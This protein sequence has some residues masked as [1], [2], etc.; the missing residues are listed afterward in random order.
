MIM[1]FRDFAVSRHG[2]IEDSFMRK[3]IALPALT[4]IA[5][6]LLQACAT[7]PPPP[8]DGRAYARPRSP[9]FEKF[10]SEME[11]TGAAKPAPSTSAE[12]TT[13]STP[14][15]NYKVYGGTGQTV[16]PATETAPTPGP[17][18]ATLAFEATD[19]R[20]VVKTV[21]F[22]ILG[23]NYYIDPQVGGNVTFRT[24][25]PVPRNT[26]IPILDML[27]RGTNA[28]LIREAGIYKV[29]PATQAVRGTTTPQLISG[30]ANVPPGHSV[31]VMPL[32]YIG[33]KEMLRIL[34]PFAK[35]AASIRG[36]ELRNLVILTGTEREIRHLLETVEMFDIDWMSGMSVGFFQLQSVDVKNLIKEFETVFGNKELGPLAGA[37]RVVPIERLNA[38]LVIAPQRAMIDKAREWIERLDSGG[39]AD[40]LKLFVYHLQNARADK[41]APILQQALTGR[42]QI[43]ST[44]PQVAPGQTPVQLG[45]GPSIG[46]SAAQ[47]AQTA[48]QQAQ[49]QAAQA[50]ARSAAATSNVAAATGGGAELAVSRNV[51][52]I[53]DK[54]NNAIV[55]LA[56]QSEFALIE[57]A[58]KKLDLAPRQV[59]IEAK[60]ARVTLSGTFKLGLNWAFQNGL[61]IGIGNVVGVNPAA[62][63]TAATATAPANP[64]G[65]SD[66]TKFPAGSGFNYAW[67]NFTNGGD[68]INAIF[69]MLATDSRTRVISTPSLIATDNQKSQIQVGQ[70]IP[71]VT[72]STTT[73]TTV[74]SGIV[75]SNQYVDTGIQLAVTP[76]VNAGGQITLDLSVELSSVADSTQIPGA[77]PN[78][79]A[80]NKTTAQ[81]VVT[82][83]SGQTILLGGLIEETAGKGSSGLPFISQIPVV[84]ALFGEQT[85]QDNR[86][87]LVM[88]ITPTLIPANQDLTD[89]TNELRKKMQFLQ[90]EFPTSRTKGPVGD[91]KLDQTAPKEPAK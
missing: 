69:N 49:A 23:E 24:V 9:D 18:T 64:F 46:L 29:L 78:T 3:R 1:T 32:K 37:I 4:L 36:D 68:T 6:A 42:T 19:I 88:L 86:Q 54:D 65:I 66:V 45:T 72:G 43:Q 62:A 70:S 25:K 48:A 39:T 41:L 63:N 44:A 79:P 53:A 15:E 47:A 34:E 10:V 21:L 35:D 16:R 74:G 14:A 40:G 75:T 61:R 83:H 60:I 50:A 28:A 71:T 87:E 73:G 77:V 91:I 82:V 55:I 85:K 57:S 81:S 58:I 89:V 7:S 56:T 33:I 84:G 59:M 67:S 27:L 80:F 26:L 31:V 90:D 52:I 76:R 5:A 8:I 22:D 30:A 51:Q 13:T 11:R 38:L 20:D 17:T 2:R 12:K